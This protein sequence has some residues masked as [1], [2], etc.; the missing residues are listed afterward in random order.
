[1][2][3]EDVLADRH[4]P[5]GPVNLLDL[6]A[7]IKLIP[8]VL[9]CVILSDS[10]GQPAEI[11]A[12]TKVGTDRAGVHEAIV[13]EIRRR[14]I[15][16]SLRQVLVFELETASMLG[17]SDEALRE[18]EFLA[19]LEALN[20]PSIS[21]ARLPAISPEEAA[22]QGR[23]TLRRVVSLST[24]WRSEAEVALAAAGGGEI[25]GQAVGDKDSPGLD[26]L[27]RATLEAV[28][29]LLNEDVFELEGT[30]LTESKGKEVVLVFV[31]EGDADLV[32]AALVREGPLSEA[33]VRATLDAVNRRFSR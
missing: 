12:F 18:A 32:G 31:S 9:G 20:R 22:A 10:E 29:K 13:D 3:S 1:M 8:G 17:H 11:Q 23:P 5:S 28:H 15:D 21:E 25:L 24:T 27:A 26:V 4:P 19:E 7:V 14:E 2:W 16:G 30:W 6:E 33:A